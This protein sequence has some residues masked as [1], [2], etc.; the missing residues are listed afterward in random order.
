MNTRYHRIEDD[1]DDSFGDN[2][3]E[4]DGE[5]TP[6][7][8]E[9]DKWQS[10]SKTRPTPQKKKTAA[11]DD[12]EKASAAFRSIVERMQGTDRDKQVLV[13]VVER[14]LEH[15]R[16]LPG[17]A[18][19]LALP[20]H[21]YLKTDHWKKKREKAL[22]AAKYRCSLC[23]GDGEL[24]CHHRTYK[25]I[26]WEQPMDVICLCKECHEV[27]HTHRKAEMQHSS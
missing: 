23:N 4:F 21:E 12:N 19:L 10:H 6:G 5:C 9:A 22:Q 3:F 8:V 15:E 26:G 13:S 20:Y 18:L 27:F 25:N 7:K 11:S 1:C 14:M 17:N 16:S 24:H 2:P